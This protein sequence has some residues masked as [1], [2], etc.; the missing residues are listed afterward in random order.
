[1]GI[2]A[3]LLAAGLWIYSRARFWEHDIRHTL[4]TAFAE[5]GAGDEAII[6]I[7]GHVSRALLA[8]YSHLWMEA[9][10]RALEEIAARQRVADEKRK[11]DAER[12]QAAEGFSASADSL[13]LNQ[14]QPLFA[15]ALLW[16]ERLCPNGCGARLSLGVQ[17]R[18]HLNQCSLDRG[19]QPR[20]TPPET[21][22]EGRLET[23]HR[24]FVRRD[25]V[26]PSCPGGTGLRGKRC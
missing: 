10:Q 14:H 5:S 9:K 20:G 13:S 26:V 18:C 3:I 4:V 1:V 12:R 21:V 25:G 11:A 17:Y 6:R 2:I 16:S 7:A 15:A 8:R 19:C 24:R 23:V 22:K